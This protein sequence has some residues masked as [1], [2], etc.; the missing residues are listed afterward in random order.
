[1]ALL[2][3]LAAGGGTG[4]RTVQPPK[5][6]VANLFPTLIPMSSLESLQPHPATQEQIA[7]LLEQVGCLSLLR[8]AG[9]LDTELGVMARGIS[10]R[11]YAEID[12]RRART[13]L[14]WLA[15]AR[16]VDGAWRLA[17]GFPEYP[18]DSCRSGLSAQ[19]QPSGVARASHLPGQG[20]TP[21]WV[22]EQD[23]FRAELYQV[24]N[25]EGKVE[26]WGMTW[27][28]AGREN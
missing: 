21:T 1:M 7:G 2:L 6:P 28:I 17:A 11:G 23:G 4:C 16:T 18:P 24:L 19:E 26:R 8:Q 25:A 14:L 3:I 15:I 13:P 20:L 9:M 12:A 22:K 5:R 27:Q 10:Q